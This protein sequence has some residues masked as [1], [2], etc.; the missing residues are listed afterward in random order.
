MRCQPQTH[1]VSNAAENA[2][3][4]TLTPNARPKGVGKQS[5]E[6][7]P[8]SVLLPTTHRGQVH[9]IVDL[10]LPTPSQESASIEN[11]RTHQSHELAQSDAYRSTD[12]SNDDRSVQILGSSHNSF[13]ASGEPQQQQSADRLNSRPYVGQS[14]SEGA[15]VREAASLAAQ[16]TSQ[17]TSQSQSQPC[18]MIDADV[19]RTYLSS[20][21]DALGILFKAAE[22]QDPPGNQT[23]HRDST[24][25]LPIHNSPTSAYT[26]GS[27]PAPIPASK[28]SSPAPA[29]LEV[30]DA[31]RFIRQGWF[32]ARE[33]VTYIDL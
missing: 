22:Q 21:K 14:P 32:S 8:V 1:H 12:G 33:A 24:S 26:P 17:K 28:L 30:W 27:A 16:D 4:V 31:C 11:A 9:E 13:V 20:S 10:T 29:V 23:D 19:M 3:S 25:A 15:D 2:E 18:T 5:L 7:T 6:A